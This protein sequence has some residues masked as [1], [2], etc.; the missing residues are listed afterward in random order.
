MHVCHPGHKYRCPELTGQPVLDKLIRIDELQVLLKDYLN[1][2]K[3]NQ[4]EDTQCGSLAS[5]DTSLCPHMHTHLHAHEHINAYQNVTHRER[6]K[7]K[8]WENLKNLSE[9][10]VWIMK[11]LR[12]CYSSL[13]THGLRLALFREGLSTFSTEFT[14]LLDYI[15][16]AGTARATEQDFASK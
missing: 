16:G 9:W 11:S 10:L 4:G 15:A 1:K 7:Q 14:A 3:K 12:A 8:M 13:S 2:R 6:A 5:T